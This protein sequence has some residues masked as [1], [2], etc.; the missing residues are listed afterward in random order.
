MLYYMSVI[1]MNNNYFIYC[2]NKLKKYK[3]KV[4]Q[5]IKLKNSAETYPLNGKTNN[6]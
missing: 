1:I 2:T 4:F 6:L 5:I 3:N